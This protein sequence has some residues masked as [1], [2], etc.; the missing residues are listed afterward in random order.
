MT[1]GWL[2]SLVDVY[3]ETRSD[4]IISPVI[5]E[6]NNC[7]FDWFQQLEFLSL[8]A[9]TAGTALAGRAVMCNG[10]NIAFP[11]RIYRENSAKLRDEILS[12][13]D[14]FLLQSIR[15]SGGKIVWNGANDSAVRTAM[16]TGVR[17][18]L[19]QRARWLSKAGAYNDPYAILLSVVALFTNISLA[20]LLL[21]SL[22]VPGIFLFWLAA[23]LVKSVPDFTLLYRMARVYKKTDLLWWF[24]PSQVIYPFYVITVSAY[25]IFRRNRW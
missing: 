10:A 19:N 9:I 24:I 22:A 4:L 1:T 18:F 16:A 8:Q 5:P 25:S 21:G 23:L 14:I 15:R 13:D 2:W 11:L 6:R 17:Q 7:L 20:S 3:S 12:G